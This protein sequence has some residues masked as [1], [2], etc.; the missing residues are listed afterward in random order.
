MIEDNDNLWKQSDDE[1][2]GAT[3]ADNE[4]DVKVFVE[5]GSD[6]SDNV[7]GPVDSVE[8][9]DQNDYQISN[10]GGILHASRL[11]SLKRRLRNVITE[12]PTAILNR[13]SEKTSFEAL[14]S[15]K[16]LRTILMHTN[17]KL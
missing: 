3:R 14:I 13:R 17:R 16:I 6:S 8:E 9:V 7:K 5:R 12:T 15:E 1:E 11:I 10:P 4:G 2:Q